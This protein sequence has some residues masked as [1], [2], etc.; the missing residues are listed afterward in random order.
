MPICLPFG[1]Y[2]AQL[3]SAAL[4]S[5]AIDEAP[6]RHPCRSRQPLVQAGLRT[7]P[8]FVEF[9]FNVADNT[10]GGVTVLIMPY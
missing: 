9:D 10:S 8:L 2:S 6:R 3:S 7:L 1:A 4:L 5:H